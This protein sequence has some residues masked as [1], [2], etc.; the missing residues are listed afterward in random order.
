MTDTV[1]VTATLRA[2]ELFVQADQAKIPWLPQ[3][4][5]EGS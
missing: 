3:Q 5:N 1:N 2:A 4:Q